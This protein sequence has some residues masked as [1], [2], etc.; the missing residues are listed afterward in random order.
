V[1]LAIAPVVK[2]DFVSNTLGTAGPSN[3][4]ILETGGQNVTLNGPGT[5]NGNVGIASGG[6]LALNGSAGAEVNGNVFFRDATANFGG[7]SACTP[8]CQVTGN[9]FTNSALVGT[10]ATDAINAS[11]TFAALATTQSVSGNQITGPL[12]ITG[13]AGLNV[14]DIANLSLGNG[15]VLMLKGP[16]GAEF[17]IN[18]SGGFTLNSGRIVETGGVAESDVVINLTGSGPNASTSGGLNNESVVDGILLAPHRGIQFSPGQVNGE[19]ISG[20]NI[21]LVSGGNVNGVVVPEP[22]HTA[23]F[24]TGLVAL[25]GLVIRVR[26]KRMQA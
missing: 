15:Q 20:G 1:I 19:L 17:V 5:T 11:T 25:A 10:A 7:S 26:S 9:V 12:T 21:S 16:A 18:D 6:D 14:I 13:T 22:R 4:A 24:L 8:T 3:W 23:L 2:A